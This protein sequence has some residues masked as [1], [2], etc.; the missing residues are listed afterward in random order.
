MVWSAVPTKVR[1]RVIVRQG[2]W[3]AQSAVRLA[4]VSGVPSAAS[5]ACSAFRIADT[6][7]G[8]DAVAIGST[9]ISTATVDKDFPYEQAAVRVE[10]VAVCG[11]RITI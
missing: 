10:P 4:L 6:A 7:G 1:T 3:A 9:D 5:T 8:I 11:L 2:R